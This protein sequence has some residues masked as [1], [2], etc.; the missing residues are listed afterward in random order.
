MLDQIFMT[1]LTEETIPIARE[2]CPGIPYYLNVSVEWK[3]NPKT[4]V[5]K[6]QSLGAIGVNLEWQWASRRLVRLC[7][8][9]GLLVSVWTVNEPKQIVEMA[10]IGADNITTRQPDLVCDIIR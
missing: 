6:A 1:G 2:K 8:K 7:H 9:A 4:L 10:M 3:T 5:Q